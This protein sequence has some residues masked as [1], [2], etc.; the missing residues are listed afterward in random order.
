MKGG[1]L[2]FQGQSSLGE[3]GMCQGPERTMLPSGAVMELILILGA[4]FWPGVVMV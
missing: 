4:E 2:G 3:G 1:A